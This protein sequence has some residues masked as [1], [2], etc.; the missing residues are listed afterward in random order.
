[1]NNK[2]IFILKILLG[3]SFFLLLLS[4]VRENELRS[5]FARIQWGYMLMS[6]LLIPV[7]LA[8]SCLKWKVLLDV[9]G[10]K[11][12][13]PAL[14]RIYFIGYFF[15]NLLPSAVGGD[16]VR[17]FY[18]GKMIKNQAYAA[19][20]VFLERFTGV[21]FLLLLVIFAPLA[22]PGLYV[23]PEIFI[24][25]LGA[26]F[27]LFVMLWIGNVKDP[28]GL[29]ERIVGWFLQFGSKVADRYSLSI[30][31]KLVASLEKIAQ[32]IFHKLGRFNDELEKSVHVIKNQ[33]ILMVKIFLLTAFFYFLTW[34]NVYVSFRAFGVETPF[35]A[36][37]SLTPI[38]MFVGHLPVT[39]LGNLGFFESVFV[40]YFLLV[41]IPISETLAMMLL[42]RVKMLLLGVVG[43]VTY[44][45]YK[46]K[47]SSE[48]D[49]L[50]TFVEQK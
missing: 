29:P 23:H 10:K 47:R 44:L 7:M 15:S 43:L 27:L 40:F 13:L 34:I 45:S 6:F 25:V 35:L 5:L 41:Q 17:S 48:L 1:M 4:F 39:A 30:L 21:L 32:K 18:S 37:C 42:L 12:S 19:V 8:T 3:F 22:K 38:G 24:P 33:R 49:A 9:N 2:K 11:V 28:L 46:Y 26:C 36:I 20:C 16:V 14:M 31:I 50:Q